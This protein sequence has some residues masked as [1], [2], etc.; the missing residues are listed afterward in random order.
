MSAVSTRHRRGQSVMSGTDVQRPHVR[1]D[2][3][4]RGRFT[5]HDLYGSSCDKW[6]AE[7]STTLH[8]YTGEGMVRVEITETESN[9]NDLDSEYKLYLDAT[10]IL[11]QTMDVGRNVGPLVSGGRCHSSWRA[12]ALVPGGPC[13]RAQLYRSVGTVEAGVASQSAACVLEQK[14][15][16]D[17]CAPRSGGDVGTPARWGMRL[18]NTPKQSARVL[19]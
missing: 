14:R 2:V 10:S 8:R 7:L 4:F 11:Q 6:V 16:S 3:L 19:T 13:T 17:G 15:C 1:G 12:V 9:M 18:S 5:A